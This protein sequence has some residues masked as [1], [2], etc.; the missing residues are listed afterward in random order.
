MVGG[1]LMPRIYTCRD[2]G[3]RGTKKDATIVV[4]RFTGFAYCADRKACERRAAQLA[5]RLEAKEVDAA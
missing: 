4:S 2:C 3:Q 1:A 5:K